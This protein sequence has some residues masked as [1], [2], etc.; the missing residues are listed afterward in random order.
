M[1]GL[2]RADAL[3]FFRDVPTLNTLGAVLLGQTVT[4]APPQPSL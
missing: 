1:A 2:P 4:M 3:V